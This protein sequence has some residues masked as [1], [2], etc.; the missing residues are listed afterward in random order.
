MA[1]TRHATTSK[2][3][4]QSR[5]H[6]ALPHVEK[7]SFIRK[8]ESVSDPTNERAI[9]R[10]YN[11]LKRF[12]LHLARGAPKETRVALKQRGFFVTKRGVFV[13]GPRDSRR[14]PIPGA[15]M[16]ITKD[17]TIVWSVKQRR[18]YIVGLTK[19]ERKEFAKDPKTFIASKEKELRAKY[20]SLGKRKIQTRLQWGAYQA[21]KDFSPTVFSSKY[22]MKWLPR[23]K[24]H[25]IDKLTGLHFVIHVPR[26]KGKKH[27]KGKRRRS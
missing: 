6:R 13:D 8:Y 10:R 3:I 19:A 4:T 17:A 21:T 25:K 27:A 7:L 5:K 12:P 2:S 18:D 11:Q 24:E 16:R 9:S 20:P 26:K 22:L 23:E 14:K 15:R 1:K